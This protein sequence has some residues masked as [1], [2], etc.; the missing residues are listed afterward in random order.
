[1]H[2]ATKACAAVAILA[3]LAS[4][5]CNR[6]TL[7]EWHTFEAPDGTFSVAL[8]GNAARKDIPTKSG[9]GGTFI[10]HSLAVRAS[11]SAAYACSWWEDPSLTGQTAE[12]I[13]RTAEDSGLSGVSGRLLGEEQFTLQGHPARDIRGTTQGNAA[14]DNRLVLVGHRLYS[15][16]VVDVSGKRDSQNVKKFFNSLEL[17]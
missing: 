16:L 9:T 10:S 17:Q 3:L 11:K 1:M 12:Q 4:S 7:Y 2:L 13:L 15:L 8:P 5:D 6:A 14:Y